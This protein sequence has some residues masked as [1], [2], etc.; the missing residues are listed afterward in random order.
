MINDFA[1]FKLQQ[2]TPARKYSIYGS[3]KPINRYE[4]LKF[5]AATIAMGLNKRSWLRDYWST[6]AFYHTPWYGTI[7]SRQ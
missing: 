1:Q 4:L 7:F 3:W 2:N 5:I 6:A